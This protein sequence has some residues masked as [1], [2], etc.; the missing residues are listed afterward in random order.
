MEVYITI[1]LHSPKGLVKFDAFHPLKQRTENHLL[2]TCAHHSFH[3]CDNTDVDIAFKS[4]PVFRAKGQGTSEDKT[5]SPNDLASQTASIAV[6]S[7]T[8]HP[9]QL[10]NS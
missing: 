3:I 2:L 10:F 8:Q 4:L 7:K 5:S 9:E 1:W 6:S